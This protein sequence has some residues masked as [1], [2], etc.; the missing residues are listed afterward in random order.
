MKHSRERFLNALHRKNEGTPP[1]WMM[2]QAGRYHAHYQNLKKTHSFMELCKVPDLALEV[3][4]G[5]IE[6]FDFDAAI[7][8]SDLLFPLEVLGM[9]LEYSPGP[10]LGFHLKTPADLSRLRNVTP[11]QARQEFDFQKVSLEKIKGRFKDKIGLIGFV[12]APL[13]LFFYAAAGSHQGSLDPAREGFRDRRFQGFCEKLLPLLLEEMTVQVEGGAD[14]VAIF[15]TA[16]SDLEFENYRDQA[17]PALRSLLSEFH[18]RHPGFPVIYYSRGTTSRHYDLL[19]D[20]PSIQTIGIDWRQSV[21]E[22]LDRYADRFSIQGNFDPEYLKLPPAEFLPKFRE[23]LA[24]F[25]KLPVAK[26]KGWIAG[27]GHGVL[28]LTPEENVRNFV[29]LLREGFEG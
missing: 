15:D 4:T 18:K 8:F 3:T 23:W 25:L 11:T 28:Q 22:Y 9:G 2:R 26:R 12:G 1:V 19:T 5:P 14:V 29:K 21:P 24:P 16:A 20:I 7:L 10:T 17:V 6:D 27:L 13:T